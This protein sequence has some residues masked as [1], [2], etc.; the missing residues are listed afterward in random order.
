MKKI[1]PLEVEGKKAPR[2]ID[3]IKHEVNNY[4]KRERKK[5]LPEGVDYW[6]F[7]CR[8][9]ADSVS[10]EST[11]V[12]KISA[13]IDTISGPG[14]P[15]VYVEILSKRGHRTRKDPTNRPIKKESKK[16]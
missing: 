4:L 14:V 13:A 15:S 1:F 3:S 2:V 10:A 12:T 16:P 6:D 8:V 7:D 5:K 9:G 11:H